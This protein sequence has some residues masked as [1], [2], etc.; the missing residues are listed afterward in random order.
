MW[1]SDIRPIKPVNREAERRLRALGVPHVPLPPRPPRPDDP[2]EANVELRFYKEKFGKTPEGYEQCHRPYDEHW[3]E[4]CGP[5]DGIFSISTQTMR[6]ASALPW[7]V[8]KVEQKHGVAY[9]RRAKEN[10]E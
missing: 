9:Y 6:L 3:V 4:W 5:D 10:H 7:P 8:E 2:P 1:R